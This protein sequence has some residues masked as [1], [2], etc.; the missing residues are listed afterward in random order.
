MDALANLFNRFELDSS[1]VR[2]IDPVGAAVDT[3]GGGP[4]SAAV[5]KEEKS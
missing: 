3:I 4:E 5:A 2:A 1:H